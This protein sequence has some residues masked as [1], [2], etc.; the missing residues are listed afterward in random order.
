MINENPHPDRDGVH[1]AHFSK[2]VNASGLD[3]I[4]YLLRIRQFS[5]EFSSPLT[6]SSTLVSRVQAS[7]PPMIA[8]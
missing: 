5:E 6:Y 3:I 7:R 4:L 1:P 2:L 8:W